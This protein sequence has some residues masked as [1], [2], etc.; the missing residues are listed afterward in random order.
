[1]KKGFT[2]IELLVVVL[3]IGILSAVALPQY[4]KAVFKARVAT[5]LPLMRRWYDALAMYKLENGNYNSLDPNALGVDW[6]EGWATRHGGNCWTGEDPKGIWK[7]HGNM[8]MRG[9]ITCLYKDG[10][11]QIR[12]YQPDESFNTNL[13]GKRTC[14]YSNNSSAEKN[15]KTLG[16]KKITTTA[17]VAEQYGYEF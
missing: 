8:N 17:T 5:V 10:L 9:Q 4:E 6:P 11:T 16:G 2:L 15:C 13:A 3:I 12:Y 1:M 7:C 14:Y